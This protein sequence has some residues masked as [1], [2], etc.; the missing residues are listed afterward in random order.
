MAS[1]LWEFTMNKKFNFILAFLLA[2]LLFL[3]TASAVSEVCCEKT[4][5]GAWCIQTSADKCD[6]SVDDLTNRELRVVPSSCD[7]T[8]YCKS[9]VCYDPQQGICMENTPQRVCQEANGVWREGELDELPQCQLGC[10]GIGDQAA[11]VT[12]TRCKFLSNIYGLETNFRTDF[13]NEFACIASIIS[14]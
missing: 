6:T 12:Q 2:M 3:G 10:C 8:S 7:A 13:A 1:W 11:F 4:N 9:G 5:N 14:V